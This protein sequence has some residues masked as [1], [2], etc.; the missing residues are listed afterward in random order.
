MSKVKEII[1][2]YF[3]HQQPEDIQH[4][5]FRWLKTPDSLEEK[6]EEFSHLWD[7]ISV[8]ADSST[9]RSFQ[10]VEK[11]LGLSKQSARRSL[12][13][14]IT[15]IAAV[16]L[17]PVLSLLTAWLYVQN[18]P[19][20]DLN[21]VE[22]YVPHGE[23][24]EI[25]LPDNSQALIN[26]GSMLFY[27]KEFKGKKREIY[28]SGEA[29]FTVTPDKKKPFIVRTNDMAV[30]ALG[31]VFNVSSY[32]DNP[33]VIATLVEGKVGVDILPTEDEFILKPREQVV[34]DKETRE[35]LL[36]EARLDYVLAWEKGQMVF[37]S[38]SLFTIVK[39]LERHYGVTVYLNATGLSDE[40]L[41]V[42]FLYDES[43][44]EVLHTLQQIITGFKYKIEGEKI[45]IY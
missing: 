28:L 3:I 41:T 38:A 8:S 13:I 19:A 5:F 39:V 35:S 11:R 33:Y 31:T 25:T 7:A 44:E 27:Q 1:E 45:Y 6:E 4:N 12:Y 15:R 23:I 20:P 2:R 22:Y 36:K 10:Q 9:E 34:Y 18:Q 14:R 26:S 37:Q 29:K 24:R 32:A 21:L 16:F 43:L 42:K 40:K 17:I 30:E